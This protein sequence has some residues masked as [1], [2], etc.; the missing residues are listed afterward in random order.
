MPPSHGVV[1]PLVL[2]RHLDTTRDVDESR[3]CPLPSRMSSSVV[4][5]GHEIA[6]FSVLVRSQLPS[7]PAPLMVLSWMY[8][9]H[10]LHLSPA[11]ASSSTPGTRKYRSMHKLQRLVPAVLKVGVGHASHI[12]WLVKDMKRPR[13]PA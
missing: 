11:S 13:A 1:S 4:P 8:V 7:T 2:Q 9:S 6:S 12:S 10:D 3:Q 5:G